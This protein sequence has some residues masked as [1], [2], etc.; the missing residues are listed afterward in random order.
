MPLLDTPKSSPYVQ[1]VW[2]FPQVFQ[3]AGCLKCRTWWG[4]TS[5]RVFGLFNGQGQNEWIFQMQ[6]PNLQIKW[7]CQDL[8]K[9]Y[10]LRRS[11]AGPSRPLTECSAYLMARGKTSESSKC[12]CQIFKSNGAAKIYSSSTCSGVRPQGHRALCSANANPFRCRE[13]LCPPHNCALLQGVPSKLFSTFR[14]PL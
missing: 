4:W 2:T 14:P 13:H 3:Y 9:L 10:L 7:S 11:T 12:R 8:L 1:N 6:M 5:Y